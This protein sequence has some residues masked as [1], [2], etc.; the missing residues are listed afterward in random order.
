[1]TKNTVQVEEQ[2]EE[3][4]IVLNDNVMFFNDPE[5]GEMVEIKSEPTNIVT[6]QVDASVIEEYK[7]EYEAFK[8]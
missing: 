7:A 4:V 1:M 5:Y 3:Q 2:V 8:K 6:K